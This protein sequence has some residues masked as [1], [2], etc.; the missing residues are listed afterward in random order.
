MNTIKIAL[1]NKVPD[2]VTIDVLGMIPDGIE[3]EQFVAIWN[4]SPALRYIVDYGWKQTLND[5]I[6]GIKLTDKDYSVRTTLAIVEKKIAA[7]IGGTVKAGRTVVRAADPIAAEARH[8][9]EALFKAKPIETRKK[10]I[11]DMRLASPTLD[12]AKARSAIIS[13]IAATE[14][15]KAQAV[16]NVAARQAA[17]SFDLAALMAAPETDEG[18][19]EDESGDEDESDESEDE[20]DEDEALQE[21]HGLLYDPTP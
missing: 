5:A 7:I 19:S 21:K 6:A 2:G 14:G 20:S 17:P 3:P 16:A 8:I 15:V 13:L 9:A 1:G 4:A 12:D 11:A 10:A 18:E